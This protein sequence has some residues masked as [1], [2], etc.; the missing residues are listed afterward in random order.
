MRSRITCDVVDARGLDC[1]DSIR[2]EWPGG[3]LKDFKMTNAQLVADRYIEAWNETNSERRMALLRQHWSADASY[4][5]PIASVAGVG[6]IDKLI[7][8][9]QERFPG[10]T[11]A[12][13]GRADGHGDHARFKWSL[14]PAGALPPI[15][16]SDVVSLT[17]G[18]ISRVVGFLDKVPQP[19]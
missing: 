13:S 7:A 2:P 8:S 16:G 17:D 4:A 15:E 10:F 18:R 6:D 5:D 14:G 12:L 19:A 9:V 1:H 3:S 11:F